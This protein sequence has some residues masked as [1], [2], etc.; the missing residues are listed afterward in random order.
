MAV[1]NSDTPH[2]TNGV[3]SISSCG[4]E[5][6]DYAWGAAWMGLDHYPSGLEEEGFAGRR[7]G[8]YMFSTDSTQVVF[9]GSTM[10]NISML[11]LSVLQCIIH[12]VCT[13]LFAKFAASSVLQ[14]R[15]NRCISLS[16]F[17]LLLRPLLAQDLSTNYSQP[18]TN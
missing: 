14:L 4:S 2:E 16:R 13:R 8:S 10:K 11:C 12:R 17:D 1:W 18:G 15:P 3:V 7:P 5:I 6:S 9:F